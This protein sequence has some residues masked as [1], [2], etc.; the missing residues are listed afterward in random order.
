MD[1][2]KKSQ[3]DSRKLFFVTSERQG[4]TKLIP[5][6]DINQYSLKSQAVV[7]DSFLKSKIICFLLSAAI[8]LGAPGMT[9]RSIGILQEVK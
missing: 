5:T 7:C 9:D 2:N 3:G 1:K 6:R 4:S 8:H